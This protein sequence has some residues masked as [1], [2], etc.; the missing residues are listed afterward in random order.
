MTSSPNRSG[1][2]TG[3]RLLT[4]LKGN[5]RLAAA[6]L[7]V[8]G[9]AMLWACS[10]GH[11]WLRQPDALV[12][13]SNRTLLAV[14]GLLH[15]G[16]AGWLLVTRDLMSQGLLMLWLGVNYLIYRL[17]MAW[18]K[19]AIPLPVVKLVA[20]KLGASP[21]VVDACWKLLT[22]YLLLGGPAHLL[23]ERRRTRMLQDAAFLTHWKGMRERG[24]AHQA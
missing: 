11:S 18:V 22:A 10:G 7:A 5:M 23:L 20:W 1:E 8:A 14:F 17:G 24:P 13:L 19:A 16:L 6:A 4:L 3:Q 21:P 15:L 12:G 9:L 2:A